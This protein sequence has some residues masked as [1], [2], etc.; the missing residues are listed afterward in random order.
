MTTADQ[1][2]KAGEGMFANRL[3]KNVRHFRKWA[4]ARGLTAF[5][6]YDR[7]IP[8]YPYAVDLY[9]ERVHLVEYPRRKAIKGGLE[10]QREEV[11]AAVKEVL[12]VPAAY[13]HVKTHLPQPWGRSQYGRVGES[14]ERLVVEEQGLKFWV[15]LGDYLDTGLFMDHRL[16]RARVREEARGKSFLN[17]FCYTGAFTVYAAAGGA[18]RTLSV[19]LSNT[20]LDWAEDNLALNGLSNARHTLLRGDALAWV[21]SQK[22]NPEETFDLVVCDP[23]SFSTSKRMQGT[24]NVQRDHV[25]MLEALGALL[26]PGGVLYFS[27]NFLGFELKDSA[28]RHYAKVEELT[29]G[30][31]PEDFQRQQIHRC[32]R[33]VAPR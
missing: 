15:N 23:P 19:D 12:D 7:D 25:R 32:W 1:G 16:T 29:P 33:M 31:I 14:G 30:S 28:V 2:S 24:F 6:V 3:R 4:K 18:T 26:S 10:E 21:L 5:R 8:E 22:D 13:I 9:G 11:L 27:T 20:Y 17:L